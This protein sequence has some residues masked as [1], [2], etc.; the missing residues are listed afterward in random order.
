LK[1]SKFTKSLKHA[2]ARF[3]SNKH[4]ISSS[5]SQQMENIIINI[6]HP[7]SALLYNLVAG[8][9][10]GATLCAISMMEIAMHYSLFRQ[11]TASFEC[12]YIK[13]ERV[14]SHKTTEHVYRE[15]ERALNN[16]CGINL[17]S[18]D[19]GGGGQVVLRPKQWPAV[20]TIRHANS[21]H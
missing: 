15:S 4:A 18:L 11:W 2:P 10:C 16:V 3:N 5:Y 17:F 7:F 19:V 12:T 9:F 21:R 1:Y 20:G 8:T 6:E 13:R 14:Y